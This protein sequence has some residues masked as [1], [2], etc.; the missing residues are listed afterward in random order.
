VVSR[1]TVA[2][3]LAEAAQS[4]EPG[5]VIVLWPL[6]LRALFGEKLKQLREEIGLQVARSAA[7][8]GRVNFSVERYRRDRGGFP[9][10]DLASK[11]NSC[12]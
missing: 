9:T 3:L 6:L 7:F 2:R 11:Y 10:W 5:I 12:S 4:D 1:F 8:F